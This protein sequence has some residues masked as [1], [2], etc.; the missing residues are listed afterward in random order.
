MQEVQHISSG[1]WLSPGLS[2]VT[3]PV[4]DSHGQDLNGKLGGSGVS[5]LGTFRIPLCFLQ[6]K[7][8]FWFIQTAT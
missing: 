3:S 4:Y 2:F 5:S 8:L 7:W 1:S 6:M